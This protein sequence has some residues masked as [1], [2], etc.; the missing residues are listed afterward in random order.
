M[1]GP[2]ADR[3]TLEGSGD[4]HASRAAQWCACADARETSRN[5]SACGWAGGYDVPL[6]GKRGGQARGGVPSGAGGG[7]GEKQGPHSAN[8]PTLT[9]RTNKNSAGTMCTNMPRANTGERAERG[10]GALW[11]HRHKAGLNSNSKDS[12]QHNR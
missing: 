9:R 10:G 6:T 7:A 5:G 2:K 3:Q 12:R 4:C 11:R 1:R 8:G